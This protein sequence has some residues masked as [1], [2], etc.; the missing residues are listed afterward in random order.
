MSLSHTS[1]SCVRVSATGFCLLPP[2]PAIRKDSQLAAEHSMHRGPSAVTDTWF[3]CTSAA[4][5]HPH[6]STHDPAQFK[7][8]LE[9]LYQGKKV[10]QHRC[11]SSPAASPPWPSCPEQGWLLPRHRDGGQD[12]AR[13]TPSSS[14]N[15]PKH[16]SVA[17]I[18]QAQVFLAEI[19]SPQLKGS[20]AVQKT[21]AKPNVTQPFNFYLC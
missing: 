16:F 15:V 21:L 10:L 11:Q 5:D 17:L 20:N 14:R 9:L 7:A 12:K 3:W 4:R 2:A 8:E 6:A 19:S 1:F 18:G 13:F